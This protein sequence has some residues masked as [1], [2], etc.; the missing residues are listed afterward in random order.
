MKTGIII[1]KISIAIVLVCLGLYMS[2]FGIGPE[3][4]DPIDMETGIA[5]FITALGIG[6]G[7]LL[8]RKA[9]RIRPAFFWI[10]FVLYFFAFTLPAIAGCY[11]FYIFL[12]MG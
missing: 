3:G 7:T 11:Y 5:V 8:S 4:F 12:T 1:L 9:Y 2:V 10:L 6:L